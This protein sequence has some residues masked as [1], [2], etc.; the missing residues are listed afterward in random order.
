M[1]CSN[2]ATG[3]FGV[4]QIARFVPDRMKIATKAKDSEAKAGG[5]RKALFVAWDRGLELWY[6]ILEIVKCGFCVL[7]HS[8]FDE[9]KHSCR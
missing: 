5:P 3:V 8:M 6:G 4:L 2:T 1:I 9:A 7:L